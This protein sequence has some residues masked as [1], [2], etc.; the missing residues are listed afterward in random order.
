MLLNLD[1]EFC[2]KKCFVFL[3]F[4][5][6]SCFSRSLIKDRSR[7]RSNEAWHYVIQLLIWVCSDFF[8][9]KIL[10]LIISSFV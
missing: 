9:L 8:K 3:L 1:I 2:R 5:C 6:L 10:F 7:E 4:C